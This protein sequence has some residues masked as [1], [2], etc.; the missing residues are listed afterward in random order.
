MSVHSYVSS[1]T[2]DH[3]ITFRLNG[4]HYKMYNQSIKKHLGKEQEL[5]KKMSIKILTFIGSNNKVTM[6][7]AEPNI[8]YSR[9]KCSY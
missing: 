6:K 5:L 8:L 7:Y 9:P 3:F 4:M 2:N 1:Y